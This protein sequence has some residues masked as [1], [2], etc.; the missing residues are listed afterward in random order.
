MSTTTEAVR[1]AVRRPTIAV[2]SAVAI[3]WLVVMVTV[4]WWAP[5]SQYDAVG[6]RLESPSWSG[7]LTTFPVGLTALWNIAGS[8]AANNGACCASAVWKVPCCVPAAAF[9]SA[10]ASTAGSAALPFATC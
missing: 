9:A 4:Q 5:Y 1:A 3:V 2:G 6:T 7:L 10:F 8:A